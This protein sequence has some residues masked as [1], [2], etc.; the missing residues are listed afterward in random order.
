[1][2]RRRSFGR[3]AIHV[4]HHHVK[5]RRGRRRGRSPFGRRG[6]AIRIGWRM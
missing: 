1:M 4:I 5:R 6:S 2:R 3:R